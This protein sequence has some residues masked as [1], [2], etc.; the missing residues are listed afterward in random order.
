MSKLSNLYDKVTLR[1]HYRAEYE[2][3]FR[4][5]LKELLDATSYVYPPTI[6]KGEKG[7]KLKSLTTKSP[8]ILTGEL[9]VVNLTVN[10]GV[11]KRLKLSGWKK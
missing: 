3:R 10:G 5:M 7:A 11:A 4:D 1:E 9:T 8:T 6:I 2:D